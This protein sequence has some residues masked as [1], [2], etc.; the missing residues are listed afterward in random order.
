MLVV[1]STQHAG[2]N[3]S[4]MFASAR[5]HI[6]VP[7][8]T[9]IEPPLPA[10]G[11][12]PAVAPLPAA[13]ALPAVALT[14]VPAAAPVPAVAPRPLPAAAVTPVPLAPVGKTPVP[15]VEIA[16]LPAV[17]GGVVV[18]VSLPHATA[19]RQLDAIAQ[20]TRRFIISNTRFG[21]HCTMRER[22]SC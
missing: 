8:A 16:E 15:D 6:V 14:P 17:V 10:A 11:P 4:D 3:I 7:H 5:A 20:R 19:S 13:A 21:M 9:L 12:V 18:G 2:G 22:A 1:A